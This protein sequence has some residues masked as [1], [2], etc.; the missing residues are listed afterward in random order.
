MA[1]LF[2]HRFNMTLK[3]SG[4]LKNGVNNK[5]ICML[6][7]EEALR[8]FDTLSAEVGSAIPEKLTYII[9]SLGT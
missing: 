5:Y 7:R 2:I 8:Q 3:A 9:L 4:T 1:I 6:V